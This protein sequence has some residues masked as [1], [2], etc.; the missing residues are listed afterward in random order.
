MPRTT[1]RPVAFVASL[2]LALAGLAATGGALAPA[3]ASTPDRVPVATVD[4]DAAVAQPA[5]A[6]PGTLVFVKNHN[7][8]MSRG[9]GTGQVQLTRNGTKDDKYSKPTMAAN[10]IVSAIYGDSRI[11]RFRTDGSTVASW[12]SKTL[13]P[14]GEAIYQNTTS[15][16]VSPDGTKAAYG[17]YA[18]VD[19]WQQAVGAKYSSPNQLTTLA[20]TQLYF[21]D[22]T[23][24]T[25]NR[26]MLRNEGAIY[27]YTVGGAEPAEWF[28]E[29]PIFRP[30]GCEPF[31]IDEDLVT[32]ELSADGK[33]LVTMRG[34]NYNPSLAIF[35]V[36]G[37]PRTSVPPAPT[38][39]CNLT[40]DNDNVFGDPTIAPNS[41]TIAWEAAA[42]IYVKTNLDSC[43]TSDVALVVPGASDPSW[44]AAAYKAPAKP[45][46]PKS[47]KKIVATKAPKISGT[48]KVGKTLKVNKGSWKPAPS[49]YT[50]QWKRNGKAIK[51][52]TKARYKLTK[53]D[54]GKKITV[55]VTAS[56]SGYTKAAKTSKS[57]SVAAHNRKKPTIKKKPAARV[58]KTLKVTKGTWTGKPKLSYQWYR[59]S[60]KIKG[61]TK[62]KYK[63]TRADRGKKLRVK[64]TAKHTAA[65]KVS[66]WTARSK[67]VR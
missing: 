33:R 10:G 57:V 36:T 8:W 63:I 65:P 3:A 23:W 41:R 2:A 64:V 12:D 51:K 32:P 11:V 47:T 5:A 25:N 16:K 43:G 42:G 50:Y 14:V 24:I 21:S 52:A 61:A 1:T 45:A 31:C 7:V 20:P 13:F 39:T 37:N 38:L 18:F 44:S 53:S 34:P 67:K 54:A 55:T 19:V 17:Q 27:L 4:P 60:K 6:A 46:P 56:R 49:K 66:V 58:G 48:A 35:S 40:A 29:A 22:P 30:P 59:G 62:T 28:D 26:V 9:D 15:V